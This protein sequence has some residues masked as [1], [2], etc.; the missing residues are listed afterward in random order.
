MGFEL[1]FQLRDAVLTENWCLGLYQRVDLNVFQRKKKRKGSFCLCVGKVWE[2]WVSSSLLVAF[3]SQELEVGE[4]I[5]T[6]LWQWK[7]TK[8]YGLANV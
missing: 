3:S 2:I 7:E 1:R 6:E 5:M 4:F 8:A